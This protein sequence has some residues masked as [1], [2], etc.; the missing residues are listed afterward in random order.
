MEQLVRGIFAEQLVQA[1]V[2]S[3]DQFADLAAG[4]DAVFG[5][6]DANRP[7]VVLVL[8]S[9]NEALSLHALQGPGQAGGFHSHAGTKLGAWGAFALDAEQGVPHAHADA[10]RFG[11]ARVEPGQL[12]PA[13]AQLEVDRFLGVH[14]VQSTRYSCACI[15]FCCFSVRA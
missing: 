9:F 4:L 1:R 5:Q 8:A 13:P 6:K 7:T 14:G 11:E 12:A 10:V 2:E 15:T 3:D